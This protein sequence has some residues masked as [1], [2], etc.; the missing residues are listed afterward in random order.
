MMRAFASGEQVGKDMIAVPVGPE[1]RMAVV[2]VPSYTDR[3]GT[4]RNPEDLTA[5]ACINVRLP[6]YGGV[7][8]WEVEKGGREVKVRVAGPVTFNTSALRIEAALA[9]LGLA[10]V[11]RIR[12]RRSLSNGRL[13]E[14]LADWS[15]P[16]SGYHLYYPK[17]WPSSSR[18]FGIET[19]RTSQA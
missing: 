3:R 5:H 1:I 12:C 15:P 14:V 2:G 4:P 19:E 16:F 6:T 7:Y 13:V 11:S 8:A 10:F 9:G 18:R 17:P